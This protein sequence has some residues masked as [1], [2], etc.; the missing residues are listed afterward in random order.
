MNTILSDKFTPGRLGLMWKYYSRWIYIQA[1]IY[2]AI[3]ILIYLFSFWAAES[4]I[5]FFLMGSAG[6]TALA[7]L[8]YFGAIVF[9]IPA[10]RQAEIMLP[11]SV[12]EKSAFYIGYAFV[13]V[14]LFVTGVWMACNGIGSIFSEH[15]N[16][17]SLYKGMI[18]SIM[19][20]A[21]P[22]GTKT[23]DTEVLD[24]M[25]STLIIA[26]TLYGALA[27]RT[28]R[29]LWAIAGAAAAYFAEMIISI[30]VMI[31]VLLP[32]FRELVDARGDASVDIDHEISRNV[33]AATPA[34]SI[35]CFA[36]AAL[37]VVLLIRKLRH[38]TA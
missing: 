35:T 10:N 31:V 34:V 25:G 37:T 7:A 27:A 22:V 30:V 36:L 24:A 18:G 26:G 13:A 3:I 16:V 4:E 6:Q 9:A 21:T 29:V 20:I 23:W 28:Q 38:R 2:A 11:A 17:Q 5:F 15:G 19:E 14:P 33:L 8:V 32:F 1:A 12:G